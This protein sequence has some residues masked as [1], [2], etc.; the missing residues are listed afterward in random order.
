MRMQSLWRRNALGARPRRAARA[1]ILPAPACLLPAAAASEI[2]LAAPAWSHATHAV[3]P[4]EVVR[5]SSIGR[6]VGLATRC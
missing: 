3:L 2:S 1:C 6:R 4:A 5:W